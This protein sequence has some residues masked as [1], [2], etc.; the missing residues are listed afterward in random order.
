MR[1]Y[2][3]RHA[4]AV[5][6]NEAATDEDRGL[7]EIG[8]EQAQALA[9]A[10]S[11]RGIE[12]GAIISSPYVRAH[13][14]AT[15]L[16]EILKPTLPDVIASNLL[17]PER[18]RP[19]KLSKFLAELGM[20]NVAIVGHMPELGAYAEWLIG[21]RAGSLPLA[22]AAAVCVEFDDAPAKGEGEL[23]WLVTPEWFVSPVKAASR[24]TAG[25]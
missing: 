25:A 24:A 8:R 1:I 10:L 18:V 7:T 17:T 16:A 19:R 22:K 9:A 14:T 2:L 11:V 21:A 3:I 15:E 12:L 13:Q 6:K 20:D 5:A 23:M 4:E